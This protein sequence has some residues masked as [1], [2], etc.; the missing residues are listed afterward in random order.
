MSI[1]AFLQARERSAKRNRRTTVSPT[2]FDLT[3]TKAREDDSSIGELVPWL[4]ANI[5]RLSKGWVGI[6]FM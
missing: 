6:D 1:G 5:D 3:I 4:F 2:S